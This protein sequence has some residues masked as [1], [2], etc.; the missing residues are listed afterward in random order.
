MPVESELKCIKIGTWAEHKFFTL[1]RT[2]IGNHSQIIQ[3][4]GAHSLNFFA[5]LAFAERPFS[6]KTLKDQLQWNYF[7]ILKDIMW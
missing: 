7:T 4:L 5:S 1:E 6:S 2:Y 3:V